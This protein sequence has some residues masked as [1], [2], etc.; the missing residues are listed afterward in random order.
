MI[1]RARHSNMEKCLHQLEA[2]RHLFNTPCRSSFYIPLSHYETISSN[3]TTLIQPL[4]SS[5]SSSLV[6]QPSSLKTSV[7]ETYPQEFC[8]VHPTNTIH[9]NIDH[10]VSSSQD[11]NDDGDFIIKNMSS[12]GVLQKD[13]DED[14]EFKVID[15]T[16]RGVKKSSKHT[17]HLLPTYLPSFLSFY[18]PKVDILFIYLSI[19]IYYMPT[20]LMSTSMYVYLPIL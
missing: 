3:T 15:I 20:L 1:F 14:S 8:F 10:H 2:C 13:E 7:F 12:S 16:K 18:K 6:Q 11:Q 4:S 5:S 19:S 17:Y 9:T